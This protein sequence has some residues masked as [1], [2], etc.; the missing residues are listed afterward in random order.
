MTS[1]PL[2]R[3]SEINQ[4][5]QSKLGK[6]AGFSFALRLMIDS[7]RYQIA[8]TSVESNTRA[9]PLSWIFSTF[10]YRLNFISF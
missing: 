9:I 10:R 7:K 6:N 5:V 8:L 4:F 3:V 1:L 2:K